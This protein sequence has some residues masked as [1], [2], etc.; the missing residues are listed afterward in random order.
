MYLNRAVTRQLRETTSSTEA[1]SKSS[2][3][4]PPRKACMNLASN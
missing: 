2:R 3:L 1:W 4:R